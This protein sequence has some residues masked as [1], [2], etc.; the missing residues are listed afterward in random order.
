[1]NLA[2]P[3]P[4]P[5]R[6]FMRELRSA[7]RMPVGLAATTWMAELGAYALRSDTEL[8]LKSRRV[9]PG[10]L[11]DAGFSFDY[12]DWQAAVADL[13]PRRRGS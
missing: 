7:W 2:A 4:V 11:T 13:V 3:G 10:R 6:Q 12:P 8:L 1:M 5:Q 9:I